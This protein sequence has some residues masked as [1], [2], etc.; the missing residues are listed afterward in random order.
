M[1]VSSPIHQSGPS[2]MRRVPDGGRRRLAGRRSLWLA[3]GLDDESGG[4]R[5]S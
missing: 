3:A 1:T 4:D 2:G 5:A